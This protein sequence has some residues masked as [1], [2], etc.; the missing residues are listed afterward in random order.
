MRNKSAASY[1]FPA[2]ATRCV[3]RWLLWLT[4]ATFLTIAADASRGEDK[5]LAFPGAEGAGKYT[6]GGR[7]GTVYRVTNLNASGPGSLA[8]AVSQP[9]RIVVF[10]VSGVIDL[11]DEK[12]KGKGQQIHID[13]PHITIAGQTA[14]GEGICLKGSTLDVRASDVILRYLRS[15]RGF[16]KIGDMG[17]AFT[18]KPGKT[19]VQA[20]PINESQKSFDKRKEKKL[21]RGKDVYVHGD[22]ENIFFDHLSASW[23][24]DENLSVTHPNYSTVQY[25]IASEGLDYA[26]PKQT[27]P[28]H[29]EGSLWGVA[30]ANG[31]ATMHHT[32]YAHNRLRNPR[33]VSG[34]LPAAVLDFRNNVVYDASEYYCH[35]GHGA[36]CANFVNNYFKYGPSTPEKLRGEMFRFDH[37]R[38]SRMFAAGNVI[39]GF[40]QA[41][42]DN[43]LAVRYEKDLTQADEKTIRVDKPFD[44]VP[45]TTQSAVEAYETVLA[46]AGATLPA[47]D[48]VDLRIVNEV[49]SGTGHVI[50]KETDFP[51]Q[52]RWPQYHALPAP[53]DADADGIPD[54]WEE[55]F[56]LDRNDPADSMKLAAGGYANIE[57]YFNNTDPKGGSTP[58]V[59]VAAS[60]SRA[61]GHGAQPGVWR[62]M[63]SGSTSAA[64]VV[65][66]TVGGTAV[67]GRDYRPL[68]GSLTIPAGASSASVSVVPLQGAAETS[69][70]TAA[71][72]KMVVVTLETGNPHYHVGCPN[73]SLVVIIPGIGL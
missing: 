61:H 8:D 32:L 4:T 34:D 58:I 71:A 33:L 9:N 30:A 46:E 42:Q 62:V 70:K 60:V 18:A 38:D 47:R 48:A 64:L 6:A 52:Q 14:P 63:R 2:T 45:M 39:D 3:R 37:N 13:Q 11:A 5:P 68:A 66:Y 43:W 27:P 17:D 16:V 1:L 51:P 31:R 28:N 49:R 57:H 21:S 53:A 15:R 36:I 44:A 59:S 19:G 35:T 20:Q 73:A 12:K 72:E 55:Q 26:N 69:D 22:I 7:G 23:A 29:S 24:T 41:T 56:G 65:N 40:P 54:Y 67:P 25:C 50:E 10:T